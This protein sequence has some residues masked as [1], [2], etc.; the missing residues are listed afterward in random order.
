MKR[1]TVLK[2]ILVSAILIVGFSGSMGGTQKNLRA[3]HTQYMNAT[4]AQ[5][6]AQS[7]LAQKILKYP[8]SK[9]GVKFEKSKDGFTINGDNI[10]L[11]SEGRIVNYGYNWKDGSFSYLIKLSEDT[12]K[13]KFNRVESKQKSIDIATI[14]RQGSI[15]FVETNTGE[16]FR[17]RGIILTSNGFI[18][19]R[20]STAFI[21]TIGEKTKQFTTPSGWHIAYFQ[22]GDVASTKFILLEKDKE[23]ESGGM[24]A[25][26]ALGELWTAT[27]ELG[28]AL[29]IN[30]KEDYMLINIDN[31]TKTY[32]INI[33]LG[34]KEVALYSQCKRQ[35]RYVQKCDKMDMSVSLYKPNGM[36]NTSHYYWSILWFQGKNTV[37]SITKESTHKK[38]LIR[39]LNGG[40]T[41][42][43]AYRLTGFPEFFTEQDG[44]GVVKLHVE[45]GLLPS[46]D[47]TDAEEFLN[48]NPDVSPKK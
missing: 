42:E 44:N 20:N 5:V 9:Q 11:D 40:K 4:S 37:Y 47:I 6:K 36:K 30:S 25:K 7:A 29:G 18:V 33:T 3:A 38:V 45:G 32:P 14:K 17:G 21:Y 35:N 34:D 2:S 13:I 16:K 27:K 39:D 48:K 43:A 46:V 31:P 19:T 26:T 15:F 10:Y 8:K 22:N 1:L 23:S 12:F 28:N 41:V 24:F